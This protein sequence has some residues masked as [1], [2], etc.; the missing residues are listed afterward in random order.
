M[1][2][3]PHRSGSEEKVPVSKGVEEVVRERLQDLEKEK[4]Q[5]RPWSEA[6]ARILQQPKLR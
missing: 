3:I 2:T 5:A 1:G 4:A 6:R